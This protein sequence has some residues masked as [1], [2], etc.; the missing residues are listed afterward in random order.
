MTPYTRRAQ[1]YETDQMGII[2]H[3]N[4]IR[5]FEEARLCFLDEIGFSYRR[6]TDLGLDFPTISVSCEYKSMVKFDDVVEIACEVSAL[7]GARMT[8]SYLVRDAKTNELRATG[9]TGHC[10]FKNGRLVSLKKALP[11]LF[12]LFEKQMQENSVSRAKEAN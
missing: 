8:V 11:E 5:W 7:S 12:A 3:A 10:F 1:F 4:Y 6:V 2:H 9:E